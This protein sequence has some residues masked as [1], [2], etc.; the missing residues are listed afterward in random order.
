MKN[1]TQPA[2][3]NKTP[4]LEEKKKN[5]TN[6]PARQDR[7]DRLSLLPDDATLHLQ[8]FLD[9]KSKANLKAVS[10]RFYGKQPAIAPY[11]CGKTTKYGAELGFKIGSFFC[12]LASSWCGDQA[13]T[14]DTGWDWDHPT[15]YC[16]CCIVLCCGASCLGAVT[17]VSPALIGGGVGLIYEPVDYYRRHRRRH[18]PKYGFLI[19]DSKIT[20]ST[21]K[22]EELK[23][24]PLQAIMI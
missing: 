10:K 16:V 20:P 19:P 7:K 4:L 23:A 14:L 11:Q 13:D 24:A 2:P 15:P 8:S 6:S 1:V 12:C 21:R 22:P 5:L 9:D 3:S 17:G 18:E